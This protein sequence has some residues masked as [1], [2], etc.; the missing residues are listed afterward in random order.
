[1]ENVK[2]QATAIFITGLYRVWLWFSSNQFAFGRANGSLRAARGGRLPSRMHG[3]SQCLGLLARQNT[4]SHLP[5]LGCTQL[6]ERGRGDKAGAL[7]TVPPHGPLRVCVRQAFPAIE[8]RLVSPPSLLEIFVAHLHR[9]PCKTW[10]HRSH[11]EFPAW[12]GS[13][14]KS[15]QRNTLIYSKFLSLPGLPQRIHHW[16]L[17]TGPSATL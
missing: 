14:K 8:N 3:I 7:A 17:P 11:K 15:T 13:L 4:I 16:H 12:S 2:L 1:M 10:N 5:R 9:T 6:H